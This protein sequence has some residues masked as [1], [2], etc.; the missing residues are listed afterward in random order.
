VDV[1]AAVISDLPYDAR[2]WKQVR[3]LTSAGYK[4]SVVGCRFGIETRM[5]RTQDGADVTEY[6]FGSRD[7]KKSLRVRI[8]AVAGVWR[9]ILGTKARLYHAHNIHTCAPAWLAARL[10][11]AALVYDAHELYG[12]RE[13]PGVVGALAEHWTLLVERLIVRRADVV[14]TTNESR[15]DVLRR[16]HGIRDVVVLPN[17]PP[18]TDVVEP[19]DPGYPDG[20]PVLLY[21]GWISP[22]A[23]AFR[24]TIRALPLVPDVHFVIL[25]FG[26]EARRELIRQW[27]AEEGVS[28]RVHFL[29]PRPFDE[30][31]RTAAAATM[32][33]VPIKPLNVNHVLGDTNKLHEYLMAGLPVVASDLPEIARVARDGNPPVGEVF[34]P[35][36]PESIAAAIK[37]VLEDE[38]IQARRA[39]AR[40]LAREKHNWDIEAPKLTALYGRL[41]DGDRSPA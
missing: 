40:R 10:R 8:G 17:V 14:I 23:R 28:D 15:A 24:E 32:G 36:S 18:L 16:R 39:E 2:V 5:R 19:L 9:S 26:Y 20:V 34:D 22:E 11:R 13:R 37:R 12:I 4:V 6:P 27:A 25:G 31:V 38:D 21:Q 41:L 35:L 1:C 3:S 30:L 7:A 33:L 29:P